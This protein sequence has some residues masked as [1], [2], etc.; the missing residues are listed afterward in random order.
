MLVAQ[1]H[2]LLR[3]GTWL[4]YSVRQEGVVKITGSQLKRTGVD[5]STIDPKNIGVFM[6][7][8]GMLPMSNHDPRVDDL[9]EVPVEVIGSEDGRFD[10]HDAILVYCPGPD[11]YKID[12]KT[13]LVDYENNLYSDENFFFV[14][15]GGAEGKR[16]ETLPT[17]LGDYPIVTDY[18]EFAYYETDR[19]NLLKSGRQWF[20]EE[21]GSTTQLTIRFNIDRLVPSSSL[22]IVSQVMSRSTMESSFILSLNDRNVFEQV[23][24]PILNRP[25]SRVGT[26]R[27][28]TIEFD[29]GALNLQESRIDFT[30]NF[31]RGTSGISL[32]YLDFLLLVYNRQ[33][34]VGD[35]PLIF[36]SR[37]SLQQRISTYELRSDRPVRIWELANGR[38][39]ASM[40]TS[41]IN[42]QVR[43]NSFSEVLKTF[44]AFDPSSLEEA[45]FEHVVENQDLH[46][47][48][49]PMLLIITH[50]DFR[51]EASR[52]GAYRTM[53]CGVPS[54][55]VTTE[56]IY[57]EFSGGK[58]DVTALRDY[59]RYLY[60]QPNSVLQ[61]VL[62]FGRGSYDYKG[63][64]LG[65]TNYVP[66]YQSENSLDPLE[67]Y[68]S[69]DYYAFLEDHEGLW[70]EDPFTFHTLDIGVGRLPVKSSQEALEVVDKLIRHDRTRAQQGHHW[71]NQVLLIADDGEANIFHSDA[72]RVASKAEA[73][74]FAINRIYV[75]NF[76]QLTRPSGQHSPATMKEVEL[77]IHKG[78][79]I[80]H[81]IGHGSERVLMDE[82]IVDESVSTWQNKDRMPLFITATCE[83]GRHD[84]PFLVSSGERLLLN[85]QGGAIGLI[86]TSRPVISST[87]YFLNISFYDAIAT[88]QARSSKFLGD[89]FKHTK[90]GSSRGIG[91]RNFILIGDPSVEFGIR[92]Y[93]ID[94]QVETQ[95]GSSLIKG[96]SN[97]T[98]AGTIKGNEDALR[99]DGDVMI[100]LMN[101]P[102]QKSTRGDENAPFHYQEQS[103]F[104]FR[105]VT[106]VQD[107]KFNV[108]L[109]VPKIEFQQARPLSLVA[110][111]QS[112]NRK[113]AN[114]QKTLF[115]DTGIDSHV[116]EQ[117]PPEIVLFL[118]DETFSSGGLVGIHTMLIAKINDD[119][120]IDLMNRTD[121]K[122]FALLDDSIGF[123][124]GEFYHSNVDNETSGTVHLPLRGLAP[125]SH[126]INVFASD[127]H[128]NR[129]TSSIDFI[130]VESGRLSISEFY[131][132]P[133]PVD[134]ETS[135]ALKHSRPGEDLEFTLK[136]FD[137]SGRLVYEDTGIVLESTHH[138]ALGEWTPERFHSGI[139][140][141]R[142]ELK[143]LRDGAKTT[144]TTKL[145][146]R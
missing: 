93:G 37:S 16:I 118:E 139:Y 44:V 57:N 88:N 137:S 143:S 43:F 133:N 61:F 84:D 32:G 69:D 142:V 89:I 121:H 96:L 58:Q 36:R 27:N 120:G 79:G 128:G 60:R 134:T 46:G 17:V 41:M 114:G 73:E 54:N 92:D 109:T 3:S 11:T 130:V 113:F 110:F 67:T 71:L 126:K 123:N 56:E 26:I 33:L 136:I 47:H 25:Y 15:V 20:G 23:V 100:T 115:S 145:I 138:V 68:S 9:M 39:V 94:F 75:D 65:N 83:F 4:K 122:L 45:R 51:T 80:V 7:D 119:H 104:I 1:H 108:T 2:S 124:L 40:T 129:G 74:N 85:K 22:R 91:S 31:K 38:V 117:V 144:K 63:R 8:Q 86:T 62:L 66:L 141:C 35:K 48:K 53:Q 19:I 77:Q 21:F 12:Q 78:Y 125:G 98:V 24:S 55:V 82:Q 131:N 72:E 49:A 5:L 13:G 90:N 97:V 132:Y 34:Y 64:V 107:N 70:S 127:T 95:S 87:G 6:G 30:Y 135:L 101:S 50:P 106:K 76:Q 146:I 81:Y 52:L 59:I 116:P 29:V 28:D 102:V 105:G 14:K 10:S 99:F 140:F 103:D 112:N 42:Q 18:D 111:A